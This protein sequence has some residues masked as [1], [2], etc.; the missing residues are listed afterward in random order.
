M[1]ETVEEAS[2]LVT[3]VFAR[4]SEGL[5]AVELL[6]LEGG[7]EDCDDE[8]KEG[9]SPGGGGGAFLTEEVVEKGKKPLGTLEVRRVLRRWLSGL[10]FVLNAVETHL[11]HMKVVFI[12]CWTPD[13]VG[14]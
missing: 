10:R 13:V 8:D 5:P 12:S 2:E 14:G 6:T 11:L 4:V 7:P 1:A 9:A 3:V